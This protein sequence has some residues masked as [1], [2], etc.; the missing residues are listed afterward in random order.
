M[1]KAVQIGLRLPC[2]G[3]RKQ[4]FRVGRYSRAARMRPDK[5]LEFP[6]CFVD[7]PELSK[8]MAD[9]SDECVLIK[10]LAGMFKLRENNVFRFLFCPPWPSAL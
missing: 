4:R 5:V 1:K 3:F 6:H 10:S 8:S 9:L 2:A 7:I